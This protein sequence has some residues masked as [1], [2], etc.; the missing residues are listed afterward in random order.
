MWSIRILFLLSLTFSLGSF[1]S[2]EQ[3]E[4]ENEDQDSQ[5]IEEEDGDE[6]RLDF[7]K[8]IIYEV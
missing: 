3:K 8:Y 2:N 7:L 4:D 1:F 5:E 6:G